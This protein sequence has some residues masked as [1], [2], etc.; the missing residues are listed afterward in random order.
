LG[1]KTE[2]VNVLYNNLFFKLNNMIGL[3][4]Q[5]QNVVILGR[6]KILKCRGIKRA[7]R[8][9]RRGKM[10]FFK[11][12][13]ITVLLFSLQPGFVSA[14][15][16][17]SY[18][19]GGT[20]VIHNNT[21]ATLTILVTKRGR[22]NIINEV[23]VPPASRLELRRG[24]GRGEN[25]VTAM[26]TRVRPAVGNISRNFW[27]SDSARKVHEWSIFPK[28]FGKS[29]LADSGEGGRKK[30]F[31]KGQAMGKMEVNTNLPGSDYNGGE[32]LDRPEPSLCQDKCSRQKKCQAWTYVKP[33][34]QHKVKAKC[35]LKH[36]IPKN[37]L[38]DDCCVS[39]IKKRGGNHRKGRRADCEWTQGKLGPSTC[40]CGGELVGNSRCDH[41]R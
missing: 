39:G 16:Y 25:Q 23:D 36:K 18:A 38:Q 41:L 21:D 37:K 2:K 5:H 17:Q 27:V 34:V 26:A 6:P 7:Q 13:L 24:L 11:V 28:D 31:G 14:Q 40:I 4:S 32:L 9:Q 20:L 33:G 22:T 35:W 10:R 3:I 12:L 29:F 1:N 15:T 19:R 30:N 8:H